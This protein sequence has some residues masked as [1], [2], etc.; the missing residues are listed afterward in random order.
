MLFCFSLGKLSRSDALK[1]L[2]NTRK[3][4]KGDP[5]VELEIIGPDTGVYKTFTLSL[6]L[7]TLPQ[8]LV[9]ANGCILVLCPV[10]ILYINII[11]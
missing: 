9:L 10:H 8:T 5:V 3:G 7:V 4:L 2:M 6:L 11:L 1:A